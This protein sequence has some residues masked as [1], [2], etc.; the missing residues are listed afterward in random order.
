PVN[1]DPGSILLVSK[2]ELEKA[3]LA[4]QDSESKQKGAQAKEKALRQELKSLDVQLEYHALRSPLTGHLGT[5]QIVP[6]Q[7]L[8]AGT[9]VADVVNLDSI[10]VVAFASSHA[11][12]KLRLGQNAKVLFKDL[13]EANKETPGGTI[14]YIGVQAQTETGNFLIKARFPNKDLRYRA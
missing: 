14:V 9:V 7:T 3:R 12:T 4:L 5:L 13:P 10:D 8:S 1:T 2:I 6:G 11:A